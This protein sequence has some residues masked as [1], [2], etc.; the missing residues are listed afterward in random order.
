MGDGGVTAERQR[1][2][3]GGG[4]GGGI[5]YSWFESEP[6]S[7]RPAA[8]LFKVSAA[9]AA[10][11]QPKRWRDLCSVAVACSWTT[12]LTGALAVVADVALICGAVVVGS[13]V[14]SWYKHLEQVPYSGRWQSVRP[15]VAEDFQHIGLKQ[16]ALVGTNVLTQGTVLS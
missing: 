14:N 16:H 7:R 6:Y 4:W 11:V 3:G 12:F 8:R 2:E 15:T 5:P 13:Y 10:R 1:D 9:A